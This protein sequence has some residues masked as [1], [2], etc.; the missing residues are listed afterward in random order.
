MKAATYTAKGTKS[1]DTNLPKHFELEMNKTLLAQALRVY[2]WGVHVGK[3]KA[4]TRSEISLTKSKW[5]RQKGTGRAR[6]GAKSAP[7][8]V[9]GSKA[10]GP[11]GA[12]RSLS[13]SKDMRAK[14]L[15]IALS[16]KAAEGKV[17]VVTSVSAFKKTKDVHK[18][19]DKVIKSKFKDVNNPS[20]TFVLS[21]ENMQT[22]LAIRNIKSVQVLDVRQLNAY[23]VFFGGIL[24]IDKD[25]LKKDKIE[26][27]KEN[28]K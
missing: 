17:V 23:N 18:F 15:K 8:F 26:E 1:A 10:H 14:S 3:S 5:Y 21:P 19:I 25:A 7:I 12:K 20:F 9:G 6:H 24:I 27:K 22:S 13:L 28:K 4:K 16:Q 2:E 11:D